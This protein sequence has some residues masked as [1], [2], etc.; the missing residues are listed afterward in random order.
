M[1]RQEFEGEVV[2]T[3]METPSGPDRPG[4]PRMTVRLDDGRELT[5]DIPTA[6]FNEATSLGKKLA[7]R[8]IALRA[9]I[10][11]GSF[12]RAVVLKTAAARPI[13]ANAPFLDAQIRHA[14]AVS[15]LSTTEAQAI[16]DLVD[17]S[18]A[19]LLAKLEKRL[20]RGESFRTKRWDA[21]RDGLKAPRGGLWTEAH[22]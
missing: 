19:D 22:T 15:R 5:G 9:N 4:I 17:R 1:A 10:E 11:G 14:I 18:D 13:T 16:L 12:S 2:R 20:V 7:G 6:L 8:R 21:L 3:W